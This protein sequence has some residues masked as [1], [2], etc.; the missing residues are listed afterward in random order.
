MNLSTGFFRL[1]EPLQEHIPLRCGGTC[2][3]WIEVFSFEELRKTIQFVRKLK[4]KYRIHHPFEDWLVHDHGFKG[5]VIRL[6][7][8]FEQVREVPEKRDEQDILIHAGGLQL[9]VSTLW[10]QIYSWSDIW[11]QWTGNIGGVLRNEQRICLR[12]WEYT[13]GIYKGKDLYMNRGL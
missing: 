12:G 5:V 7:G 13:L 1:H 11:G 2:L 8:V 6:R 4:I 10:S 9:G 3:A